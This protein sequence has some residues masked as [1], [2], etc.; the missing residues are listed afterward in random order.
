MDESL[1]KVPDYYWLHGL[2]LSDG[3]EAQVFDVCDS[4][5][6]AQHN[7]NLKDSL[8]YLVRHGKKPGQEPVKDL[9]KAMRC[10][11]REVR[12]LGGEVPGDI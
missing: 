8:K 2:H 10:L 1:V 11:A 9:V 3:S 7:Y 12:R 4:L 6:P 5:W